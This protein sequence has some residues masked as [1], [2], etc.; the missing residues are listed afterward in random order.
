MRGN[1]IKSNQGLGQLRLR[2]KGFSILEVVIAVS[3]L[4][5]II[6]I[7]GMSFIGI[8]KLRV[9]AEIR[10][11]IEKIGNAI[12]DYLS[13]LPIR[14]SYVI[15]SERG[16][17]NILSLSDLIVGG[18][19]AQ[20]IMNGLDNMLQ[21][22]ANVEGFNVANDIP[23]GQVNAGRRTKGTILLFTAQRGS[24][25]RFN[26]FNNNANIF[27]ITVQIYWI[28]IRN[29]GRVVNFRRLIVN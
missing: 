29:R 6:S 20:A 26:N 4:A 8:Q 19:D 7:M 25:V 14:D 18:S 15:Y 11:R 12:I 13:A 2:G 10:Y 9:N 21:N 28:D 1:M 22:L 24:T 3:L 5:L 16:D 27:E 23:N 17:N